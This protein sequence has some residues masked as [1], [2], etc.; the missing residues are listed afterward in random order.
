MAKEVQDTQHTKTGSEDYSYLAPHCIPRVQSRIQP[1]IKSTI[2][3]KLLTNIGK[4]KDQKP[5]TNTANHLPEELQAK[6]ENSFG[7]DFSGVHIHTDSPSAENINAKAYT[8]GKDV[9]FAPGEYNPSSKEGQEL[10]GHEL[11]HVVQQGQGKVGPGELH[12]KGMEIN[13]DSGLEKEADEMGALAAAGKKAERVSSAEKS[14]QREE[15]EPDYDSLAVTI[16][17]AIDGPGT[18]EDEVLQAL[19]K[20]ENKE[21]YINKLKQRYQGKYS[22]SLMDDILGDFSGDDLTKVYSLLTP[23]DAAKIVKT[24]SSTGAAFYPNKVAKSN[25]NAIIP[26]KDF[27][28]YVV[29]IE[30]AYPKD[31][32]T[33]IITRLRQMYYSGLA[34][35]QLIPG[36]DTR[37]QLPTTPFS[38]TPDGMPVDNSIPRKVYPGDVDKD[39]FAH[40]AAHADENYAG[41]N[42]SPYIKLANGELIDVGHLLLGLD[43]LIHPSASIPYTTYSVPGIDPSSWV[44]DI[45][46]AAVWAQQHEE[47]GF[48]PDNSPVKLSAPSIE[49]YYK[50]SA[51]MPDI[52]GDIDS[53]G[54]HDTFSGQSSKPLSASLSKYYLGSDNVA[55]DVVKRYV[56]F[57]RKNGLLYSVSGKTITWASSVKGTITDRVNKFNDLF[58]A[59]QAGALTDTLKSPVS[60]PSHKSWKYTS[61]VIDKFLN[62]IKLNTEKELP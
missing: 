61:Y 22:V 33:Q 60:S 53:F 42:P 24:P 38:V 52:L 18:A 40:I 32:N 9:H 35:D 2:Q 7:Q 48:S 13:Q 28:K 21:G 62:F 8:Q 1:K 14:I 55:P 15:K 56:T 6:M 31:S 46:I 50:I 57:C 59:G 49:E 29:A 23:H 34:F 3:T 45:G 16:H 4:K 19:V 26:I 11:T 39:T 54:L 41:D 37:E 25:P 30:S 44:A 51:P 5:E 36:A 27:I 47:T 12:G 20:L 17:E 43:S 10:I 58:G